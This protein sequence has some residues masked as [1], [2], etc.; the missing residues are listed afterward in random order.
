MESRTTS[1][2]Q[3]V[4]PIEL[5][6]KY[7]IEPGTRILIVDKESAIVLYPFTRRF[8]RSLRGVLKNRAA[9]EELLEARR[10]DALAGK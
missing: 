8:L 7:G 1:K 10:Q 6:R 5:R 3:I 2:G 9:L 4:I